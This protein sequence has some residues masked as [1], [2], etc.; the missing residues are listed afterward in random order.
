MVIKVRK[1]GNSQGIR[2]SKQTLEEAGIVAGEEVEITAQDGVILVESLR[3]SREK[4]RLR[5]LVSQIPD[6]NKAEE[7]N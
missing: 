7:M 1:W 5:D 6:G 3:R 4:P 2:L